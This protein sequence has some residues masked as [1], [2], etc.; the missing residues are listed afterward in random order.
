MIRKSSAPTFVSYGK[1]SI[2][3]LKRILKFLYLRMILKTLLILNDLITVVEAP[4]FKPIL[5]RI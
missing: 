2:N 1:A 3:V 5:L 4:I